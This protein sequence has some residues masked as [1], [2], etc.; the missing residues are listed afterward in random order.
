MEYKDSL[1]SSSKPATDFYL[2]LNEPNPHT[3]THFNIM[4]SYAPS[5]LFPSINILQS[6]RTYGVG[7]IPNV[8]F[9]SPHLAFLKLIIS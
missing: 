9:T 1:P 2:G 7:Q 8:Y 5:D 6:L 4:F 3:P